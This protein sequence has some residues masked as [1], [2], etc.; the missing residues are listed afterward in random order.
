M[1]GILIFLIV[2]FHVLAI[3]AAVILVAVDVVKKVR[4]GG[5]A[6]TDGSFASLPAVPVTAA[7]KGTADISAET[8]TVPIA[9]ETPQGFPS[10]DTPVQEFP[11]ITENPPI[12]D[13]ER[14]RRQESSVTTMDPSS[15]MMLIGTIFVILSGI[16]FG[17]AG[18]LH[19]SPLGRVAIMTAASAAAFGVSAVFRKIFKLKGTS[20][21]FYIVG[22]F[23]LSLTVIAAGAYEIFGTW[24]S[25]DGGGAAL[26]YA[27]SCLT[28]GVSTLIGYNA[29]GHKAFAYTGLGC[30]CMTLLCIALQITNSDAGF[31]VMCVIIQVFL[32]LIF[33]YL[34]LH[35]GISL[36]KEVS[37]VSKI[38]SIFFA[39][40][41]MT[42]SL[43]NF[44]DT[45][46]AA[47]AVAGV[48]FAESLIYA[49]LTKKNSL[50]RIQCILSV[51]MVYMIS[52]SFEFDGAEVIFLSAAAIGIYLFNSMYEPLRLADMAVFTY[53]AAFFHCMTYVLETEEKTFIFIPVLLMTAAAAPAIFS[54]SKLRQSAAGMMLPVLPFI[55]ALSYIDTESGA[56]HITGIMLVY[57]AMCMILAGLL[58]FL[59]KYAFDFHAHH[60][61]KTNI[62]VSAQL[63]MSGIA[64]M[65][66]VSEMKL[67]PVVFAALAVHAMLAFFHK[68]NLMSGISMLG[69]YFLTEE[70]ISGI[71]DISFISC[72]IAA[73]AMTAVLLILS[74]LV[75]PKAILNK[76]EDRTRT[77]TFL[78]TAAAVLLMKFTSFSGFWFFITASAVMT[79]FVKRK[80]PKK[81]ASVILSI[82]SAM[83][84][85]AFLDR[86]FLIVSD[87]MIGNKITLGIFALMGLS[88]K[89]IWKHSPETAKKSSSLIFI[90]TFAALIYDA[91]YFQTA[92]NTIFVLFVTLTV[93]LASYAAKSKTW[94]T[95][96]SIAL[97]VITVYASLKYLP[98]MNWW[99]Y[100]F[101]A[102]MVLI[103]AASV[104]E[105]CKSHG[106]TLRTALSEKFSDW[107]W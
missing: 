88:Y 13:P 48:L 37:D 95:A 93:L 15:V 66:C 77:D 2:M 99:F 8:E 62:P 71:E 57:S 74:R 32:T 85:F 96:S 44:F 61:I 41:A 31:A 49:F 45:D 91:I 63:L 16:A 72:R 38:A 3:P 103:G 97:A 33:N 90:L 23:M 10:D 78:L 17:T 81:T 107:N 101:I 18:W 64:L 68:S 35:K 26:L 39:G 69:I 73:L 83:A 46:A 9:A 86:P 80:T 19:T 27:V 75:F 4:K 14:S 56:E 5:R 42:Y 92:A 51:Y 50:I 58:I 29:Y 98:E 94:F 87:D 11:P 84:A 7:V 54:S 40:L 20:T 28:A 25:T 36:E 82:S 22:S 100:L 24:F 12:P 70:L 52:A 47:F 21:A 106:R 1:L 89:L 67:V 34:K 6:R 104:N 76:D 30:F 53:T 55:A 60:E 65:V 102:G 59:P 105:Y 79:G 43:D